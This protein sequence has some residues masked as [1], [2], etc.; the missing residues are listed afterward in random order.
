[1]VSCLGSHG[2]MAAAVAVLLL[3]P[4]PGRFSP[5]NARGVS[6][7]SQ[8]R[9]LD[10]EL[11]RRDEASDGSSPPAPG[12][13]NADFTSPTRA[14]ATRKPTMAARYYTAAPSISTPTNTPTNTP[15]PTPTR[16]PATASPVASPSISTPTNTP[17]PTPT[18]TPTPTCPPTTS[19]VQQDYCAC[20]YHDYN[21]RYTKP[22]GR[23]TIVGG[24]EECAGRCSEYSGLQYSGGCRGFMTGMYY[25]MLFCRSY[26]A[27]VRD[28]PCAP[29]A[30]PDHPGYYSGPIA[31]QS[32]QTGQLNVGGNCC[33]N[34]TFVNSTG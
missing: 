19:S 30:K 1:M 33:S 8:N 12:M 6:D 27:N 2:T 14:P 10:D 25:G 9:P 15:T 4:A 21:V 7:G 17:T 24:H 5:V 23:I 26:G 18:N 13:T 11:G 28:I 31:E 29:W 32:V 34:I 3:M 16:A 22:L 20:G